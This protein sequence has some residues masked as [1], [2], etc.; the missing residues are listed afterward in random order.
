MTNL[1][2]CLCG[3]IAFRVQEFMSAVAHCHCTMCRKFHGA[4]FSTF[5]E[6]S[7]KHISF[8]RGE[9]LLQSYVADNNSVRKFCKCCGSSLIFESAFNRSD[10]TIEVALAAFDHIE[11]IK[12]NAHIYVANKAPWFEITDNIPQFTHFRV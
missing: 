8:T 10:N 12:P 11:A 4:A 1:A 5:A 7:L 2:S 9:A 3:K 6:V